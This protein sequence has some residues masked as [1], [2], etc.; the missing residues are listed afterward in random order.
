MKGDGNSIH[1]LDQSVSWRGPH[2][3]QYD[4]ENYAFLS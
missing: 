2:W 1:F 3:S 4:H